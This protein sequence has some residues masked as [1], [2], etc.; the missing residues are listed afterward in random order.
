MHTG[1]IV[2]WLVVL[3]AL[4]LG[5]SLSMVALMLEAQR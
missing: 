3:S 2:A 5:A 4:F 1:R